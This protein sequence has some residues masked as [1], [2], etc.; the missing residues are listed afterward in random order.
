MW[1]GCSRETAPYPDSTRGGYDDAQIRRIGLS[2]NSCR[3]RVRVRL[4]ARMRLAHDALMKDIN[5]SC[6]NVSI[7]QERYATF[8]KDLAQHP[9]QRFKELVQCSVDKTIVDKTVLP[10]R[11]H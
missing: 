10:C 2:Q 6:V 9:D 7:L 11:G 1:E 4:V 8:C 5:N 3:P